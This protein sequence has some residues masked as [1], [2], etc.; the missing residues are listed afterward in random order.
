MGIAV[1]STLPFD[2]MLSRACFAVLVLVGAAAGFA[3]SGVALSRVHSLSA[4]ASTEERSSGTCVP[5]ALK[6]AMDCDMNGNLCAICGHPL[7]GRGYDGKAV[8]SSTVAAGTVVHAPDYIL[9][10]DCG[11]HS[12]FG[13]SSVA[14]VPV[15]TFNQK[16]SQAAFPGWTNAWCELNAQKVCSDAIVN[17]DYLFQGKSLDIPRDFAYDFYYCKYNGWLSLESRAA[18]AKGF[19]ALHN[20]SVEVCAARNKEQPLGSITTVSQMT[21]YLPGMLASRPPTVEEA[22]YIG[23][24]TCAMGGPDGESAGAGCDMA[25]CHYTYGEIDPAAGSSKAFCVYDDCEGWDPMT[26]MPVVEYATLAHHADEAAAV[27]L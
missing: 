6:E 15:T 18:V 2:G 21:H 3:D 16:K 5:D 24:W 10:D 22:R 12:L 4:M 26:G 19:D 25:Y 14:L 9:R 13:S 27:Y 7:P 1:V 11:N 20:H 23:S 8:Y 17:R